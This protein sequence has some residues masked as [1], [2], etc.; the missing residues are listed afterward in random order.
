MTRA[1]MDPRGETLEGPDW[2]R[3]WCRVD[4]LGDGGL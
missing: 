4:T 3:S 1:L 2:E